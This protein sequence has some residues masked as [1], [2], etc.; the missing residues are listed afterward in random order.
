MVTATVQR[1]DAKSPEQGAE[2]GPDKG[3]GL[4]YN[5]TPDFP[6]LVAIGCWARELGEPGGPPGLCFGGRSKE[7]PGSETGSPK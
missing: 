4:T 2:A 1:R 5:E 7:Q 6:V 3:V